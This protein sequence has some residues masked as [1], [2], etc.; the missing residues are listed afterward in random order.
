MARLSVKNI[1]NAT[2][3][4]FCVVCCSM[5]ILP[6]M[7][8][9]GADS[10]EGE[11]IIYETA[12]QTGIVAQRIVRDSNGLPIKTILYGTASLSHSGPFPKETL[13]IRQIIIHKYDNFG[14]ITQ[15]NYY[16]PEMTL[17][18]IRDT[19]YQGKDKTIIFHRVDRSKE[20]EIRYVENRTVS[21]LYYDDSGQK[22]IGISGVIPSDANLASG[23]GQ[24]TDGLACGIGANDTDAPLKKISVQVSFRNLTDKPKKVVTAI[25]YAEVKMELRDTKGN[26]ILQNVQ[27]IEEKNRHLVEMN[28]GTNEAIGTIPAFEAATYRSYEL[29]EWYDSL[30][31]GKYY[32]TVRCRSEG[33]NFNLV[34]NILE[35][36]IEYEQK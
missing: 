19:I 22:L 25:P 8:C 6:T 31:A 15:D 4:K 26:L 34:S 24:P 29:R 5:I 30:A 9:R 2:K 7:L 27:Y 28:H 16:T 11:L 17:T 10:N 32:L 18:R 23:W 3:N 33:K 13:S 14:R 1:I 12:G 21:H 20:Y 36:D 35:L